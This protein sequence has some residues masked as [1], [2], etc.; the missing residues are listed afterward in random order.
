MTNLI[1]QARADKVG[2]VQISSKDEVV[3]RSSPHEKSG[4][5]IQDPCSLRAKGSLGKIVKPQIAPLHE[6]VAPC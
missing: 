4:G 6:Q 2:K 3:E 5:L 1:F